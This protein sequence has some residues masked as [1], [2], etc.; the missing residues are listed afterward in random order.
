MTT[1]I[2]KIDF[3]NGGSTP[4]GAINRAINLKLE[5]VVSVLDFGADNTGTT[6]CFTAITNALAAFNEIYFPPGV[7]KISTNLTT[8]YGKVITLAGGASFSVDSGKTLK[9]QSEFHA[10]TNQQIFSGAGTVTGIRVVYPE[11]FGAVGDN[12]TDDQPAFQKCITCIRDFAGSSGGQCYVYLSAKRYALARTWTIQMSAGYGIYIQGAN[13]LLGGTALV[14]L[15]SFDFSNGGVINVEGGTGIDTIIDFSLRGFQIVATTSNVGAGIVFN[16]ISTDSIQGLQE[17][18]VEDINITGFNYGILMYRTRLI[19]FNRVSVWND[20]IASGFNCCVQI[21]DTDGSETGVV[22]G[23]MTWT[24]CQFVSNSSN[25]SGYN[26]YVAGKSTSGGISGMRFN[27]CIFYKG[28]VQLYLQAG[29]N[30]GVGDIWI[31]NCQFDGP[32]SQ[33]IY[34]NQIGATST[35]NIGDIHID[36]NYFT[37]ANGNCV[38]ATAAKQNRINSVIITNNYSAGVGQ[39][40]V[41]LE[42]CAAV[43]ISNNL[44]S[45]CSWNVY[46]GSALNINNSNEINIIGNNFGIAGPWDTPQGG[47]YNMINLTGTGDYYVVQGNNS[48]G[49]ASSALIYNTTGAA[50]T[51]ITG[52]I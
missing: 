39:A 25:T 38:R 2:P 23:D 17:S 4:T 13:T 46:L 1:L 9:I 30:S 26:V 35:S 20:S 48:C 22:T 45:G 3:K 27:Q 50:H 8:A 28:A 52:N 47:F 7:Y 21:K 41:N 33:G 15:A 19:N 51:S 34:L 40:A 29:N 42:Y 31:T 14:A 32:Q 36:G 10:P 44:F 18:L 5:E 43:N 24:D 12:A 6:D 49:L 16:Q 11:W 37:A